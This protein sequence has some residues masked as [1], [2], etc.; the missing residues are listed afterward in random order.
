MSALV[1]GFIFCVGEENA[2]NKHLLEYLEATGDLLQTKTVQSM[3]QWK[4][5]REVLCLDHCLFVSYL[6]FRAAKRLGLDAKEAARAGLLHDLYLYDSKDKSAHPGYQ[7]FDHP[8]AAARNASCLTRL[9]PREENIIL[10]HM[11]P[12]GGALPRS[13]EALLVDFIDTVCAGLEVSGLYSPSC[14][15]EALELDP[16]AVA[17]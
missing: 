8:K 11:W 12:L 6:S 5:H 10:S 17:S 2:M 1:S 15:R 3:I 13:F 16:V 4:H 7:C 9:S 14:L